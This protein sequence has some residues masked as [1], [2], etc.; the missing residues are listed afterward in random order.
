MKTIADLNA[1]IPTICDQ[2][3]KA[4]HE[5]GN[6]C[7]DEYGRDDEYKDNIF[8]YEDQD[9]WTVEATYRCCGEY[10][11]EPGDY[12]TP[13]CCELVR[14]WGNVVELDAWHSGPVTGEVTEFSDEDLQELRKAMNEVLKSIQV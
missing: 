8:T 1:L 7:Y 11:N 4:E 9:G 6:V 13:P 3:R 2:L 12:W 14:A 10:I 5:I